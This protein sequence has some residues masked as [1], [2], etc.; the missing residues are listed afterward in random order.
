[1]GILEELG[2][3]ILFFDG[4]TGSLL[5]ERGLKP[6]ELP[7]TWNLLKPEVVTELHRNYLEAGSDVVLTN[8]FG[9][10]RL[11]YDGRRTRMYAGWWRPR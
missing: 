5:Q 1:M 11:K 9:A 10:N 4:G 6:G 2:K 8:T 7:E 3:R